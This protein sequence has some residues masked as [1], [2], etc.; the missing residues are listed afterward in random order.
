MIRIKE[1]TLKRLEEF[2]E[3]EPE[4]C[5]L[6]KDNQFIHEYLQCIDRAIMRAAEEEKRQT[7]KSAHYYKQELEMTKKIL[8][9]RLIDRD[10]TI[11]EQSIRIKELTRDIKSMVKPKVVDPDISL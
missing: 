6:M 2:I 1:S 9:D 3:S 10:K 8:N 5:F 4:L 7:I 11:L